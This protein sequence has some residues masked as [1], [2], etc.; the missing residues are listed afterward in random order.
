MIVAMVLMGVT[1]A[2]AG[3]RLGV[4]CAANDTID[5]GGRR[6]A[7]A[8]YVM[9]ASMGGIGGMSTVVSPPETVKH[10]YIGQLAE[11][12]GFSVMA[13]VSLNENTTSQLGGLV[14]LDDSSL[15]PLGGSEVVWSAASYPLASVSA[16]GLLTAGCVYGNTSGSVTGSTAGVT[17]SAS[18]LVL[19]STPDNFGLYASD[20]LPDSW[21]VQYYGADNASAAP[22]VDLYGTGDNH[23]KY[24]AGLNPTNP[25]AVFTLKIGNGSNQ[26]NWRALTFSPRWSDRT[27]WV[28]CRTNLMSGGFESLG[29]FSMTDNGDERTITDQDASQPRK[30]YRVKISYP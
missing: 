14:A 9:D 2:Q 22:G 25:A 4:N 16:G 12:A 5:G 10:G 15:V 28:E 26:P 23:F 11:I 7:S 8:N 3:G 20:G 1:V 27:Y 30:F 6:A 17:A 13:P 19:D 29:S 24:V 21:Q 18:I